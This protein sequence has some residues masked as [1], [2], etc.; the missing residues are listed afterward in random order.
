MASRGLFAACILIFGTAFGAAE[1]WQVETIAGTGRPVSDG[2]GQ[3][4]IHA[5]FHNPFG[6]VRGPDQ[7]LYIAEYDGQ[8]I[9]K[10]DTFGNVTTI[11]GNG[12]AGYSGD[13]GQAIHA[14]INKPHE[15]VFGPDK[16]LYFTDMA[17]HR[18]RVVDPDSG[19]ISTFAGNGEAGLGGDG[20]PANQARLN[21]PHS[22]AFS[23]QGDLF[24]CDIGNHRIRRVDF[25]TGMISTFAGNGQKG[26]PI[27]KI[28]AIASTPLNGPRTMVFDKN[29]MIWLALRE[30]NQ[31]L[32]LDPV[33]GSIHPIAG[34]GKKGFSQTPVPSATATFSGPKGIAVSSDSRFVYLADTESHSIRVIDNLHQTVSTLCGN[35]KLGDGPDGNKPAQCRLGRPHGV[36]IDHDGAILIGDSLSHK[37]RRLFRK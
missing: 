29:G 27:T 31:V 2:D 21:K 19:I 14:S 20:G 34:T 28:S 10:I 1:N 6:V 13:G 11:A 32:K 12:K 26:K 36:F 30:G 5:S 9:R 3:P 15:I 8:R 25:Q 4:A 22:L 16:R 23:P 37:I 17:N 24:I 18:I 35:G 33:T 7:C